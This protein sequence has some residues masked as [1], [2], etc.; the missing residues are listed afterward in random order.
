MCVSQTPQ[1]T[2]GRAQL[3]QGK[4]KDVEGTEPKST[5]LQGDIKLD[6]KYRMKREK[7]SILAHPEFPLVEEKGMDVI[8]RAPNAKIA[9]F[10]QQGAYCD[11]NVI[12]S[13]FFLQ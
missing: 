10:T 2:P 5:Q 1:H 12:Y 7:I 11:D 3:F 4:G 6:T 13:P 9:K 8:W